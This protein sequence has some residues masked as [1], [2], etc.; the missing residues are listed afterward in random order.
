ML[1]RS[2]AWDRGV[3][4]APVVAGLMADA[5]GWGEEE[6]KREIE[7][8]LARVAAERDSQNQPDD[9]TAEAARLEAPDIATP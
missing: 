4:A 8:Y 6:Q 5:L 2:E 9:A 3:S 7:L 1:F